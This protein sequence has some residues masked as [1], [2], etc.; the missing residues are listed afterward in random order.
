MQKKL[1]KILNKEIEIFKDVKFIEDITFEQLKK[2][3]I[4]NNESYIN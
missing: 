3:S 1:S 2:I 4:K